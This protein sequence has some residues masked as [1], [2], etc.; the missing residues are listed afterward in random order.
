[1]KAYSLA[2]L[3]LMVA[4]SSPA[5]HPYTE[6]QVIAYAKA[7]DVKT[8]DSSLPSQRLEDWLQSGPPH[9]HIFNWTVED[10]C[11]LMGGPDPNEDLPLCTRITFEHG[12]QGGF[13]LVAVG[14]FK[15][16][17]VGSPYLHG[18]IGVEEVG[19]GVGTGAA[20]RLSDLP[21]LLNQPPISYG[22]RDLYRE[23]VAHHP[24]GIPKGVDK[25]A[26]W[27][28]LSKRLTVHLET[29]QACQDDYV[30]QHPAT[31]STPKPNWLKSGLF[32]GDDIHVAPIDAVI[33]RKEKQRD[34]SFLVYLVL[35]YDY[36]DL[37]H[38]RRAF[39]GSHGWW[40]AA[41]V[42]FEDGQFVVD[43]VRIFDGSPEGPYRLLSDSF[44]GCDG[45]H[46]NGVVTPN[47]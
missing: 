23:I 40:V 22:V 36:I 3:L 29:A 46:W 43:D 5:Q 47:E 21:G 37:G 39:K 2:M 28:L 6:K 17:I 16:G 35:A 34:G 33:Q 8:L 24:I 25:A 1:M 13:F 11:D 31:D 20:E 7:I 30:R 27:P 26:I 14:T 38:G 19:T 15:S 32:S 45:A 9:A 12:S 4:S 44:I 42:I 10:T 41:R 18:S